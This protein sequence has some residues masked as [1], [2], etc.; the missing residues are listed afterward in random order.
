MK[1]LR[2]MLR[3]GIALVR[4]GEPAFRAEADPFGVGPFGLNLRGRG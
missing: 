2:S 1:A 3:A 4:D